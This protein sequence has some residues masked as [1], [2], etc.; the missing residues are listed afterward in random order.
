MFIT[1]LQ[2]CRKSLKIKIVG[3]FLCGG[4]SIGD[5]LLVR[6]LLQRYYPDASINFSA[7]SHVD[8]SIHEPDTF[9]RTNALGICTFL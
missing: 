9:V 3:M 4:I 5:A 2:V 6:K 7:E 1:V 8:R